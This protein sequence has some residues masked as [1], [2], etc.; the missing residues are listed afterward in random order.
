VAREARKRERGDELLPRPRQ[1]AAHREAALAQGADELERLIGRD[2]APNDQ[3]DAF[4]TRLI[5]HGTLHPRPGGVARLACSE[6]R[7]LSRLRPV[8]AGTCQ[9]WPGPPG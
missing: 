6:P 7:D 8:K 3:K 9:G 1:D 5:V 4:F 2:A